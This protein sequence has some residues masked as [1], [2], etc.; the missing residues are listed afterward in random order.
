I[1]AW[2]WESV[3]RGQKYADDILAALG[4]T[5]DLT[6]ARLRSPIYQHFPK[7]KR[8]GASLHIYE[9]IHDGYDGSV[10]ITHALHMYNRL[11]ADW[12]YNVCDRDSIDRLAQSDDDL[13]ASHT[14][15]DLLTKRTLPA[16]DPPD[17]QLFGRQVY[18]QKTSG[19]IHL[20]IFEGGHEQ[21]PQALSVIPVNDV[22][23]LSPRILTIGDSNAQIEGGWVDQLRMRLP[24]AT[25]VNI[26]QSGRT[27]GFDNNGKASLNALR[28]I[29]SYLTEGRRKLDG[30]AY[31][32][33]IVCLGTNDTKYVFKERQ[34][35]VLE[36][37]TALLTRI[38]KHR[39]A[40]KKT[41]LIYVSPPPSGKRVLPKNT[42]VVT[43]GWPSWYPNL[44]RGPKH[45]DSSL[46]MYT[47]PCSVCL[48]IMPKT[49]STWLLKARP[50]LQ[51]GL[52]RYCRVMRPFGSRWKSMYP[53]SS[54]VLIRNVNPFGISTRCWALSA[55]AASIA[56]WIAW[57]SNVFPSPTAP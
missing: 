44:R 54:K 51:A 25:I 11:V 43:G 31:D 41:R 7:E 5:F 40:T 24:Q 6:E 20:T 14:I 27:I 1:E 13:I 52:F 38:R 45:S 46:W 3:G 29:D 22:A 10:P 4:G 34:Q 55:A 26:S 19:N 15:I 33:I 50:S 35:E 2:Y 18:L 8:R 56:F 16:S 9:G 37:F 21:L 36:N 32:F 17:N 23:P 48:I 39:V 12:K 28:H 30:A 49:G 42:W 47:I 57:V 53:L